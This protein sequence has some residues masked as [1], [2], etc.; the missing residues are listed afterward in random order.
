MELTSLPFEKSEIESSVPL[1]FEKIVEQYP[2][3]TAIKPVRLVGIMQTLNT[4]ANRL[5]HP[6]LGNYGA[7]S[8][9][10]PFLLGRVETQI[11]AMLGIQKA[12]KVYLPLD[13][14][15]PRDRLSVMLED[16]QA[17]VLI[18]DNLNWSLA[19]ELVQ[20]KSNLINADD[21]GSEI[22]SGNPGLEIAPGTPVYILYTSGSS[23]Q[24]KGVIQNQRNLLHSIWG[25]TRNYRHYPAGS[26]W[27]VD[28]H[29]I[30][31]L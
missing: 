31:C 4:Q 1:Q 15:L 25:A 10:V 5:A 23:G 28:L 6:L 17:R 14:S 26:L 9:P 29:W 8:E 24:P 7:G 27:A 22:T 13:R 3:R 12:G 2:D 30:C 19:E 18:T 21:L 11:A 16:S 20:G